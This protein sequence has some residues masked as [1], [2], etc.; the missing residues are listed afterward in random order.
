[1]QCDHK[2]AGLVDPHVTGFQITQLSIVVP[3]Y[4]LAPLVTIHSYLKGLPVLLQ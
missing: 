2:D 3:C 4:L 1:M